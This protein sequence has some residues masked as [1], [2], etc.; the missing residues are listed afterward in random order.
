MS[1]RDLIGLH[2]SGP[3]IPSGTTITSGRP[4][5]RCGF[6]VRH[7]VLGLWFCAWWRTWNFWRHSR[8]ERARMR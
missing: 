4:L 7:R 6:G 8:P 5:C 1:A 3:G 2:V